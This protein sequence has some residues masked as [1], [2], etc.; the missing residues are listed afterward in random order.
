M[1]SSRDLEEPGLALVGAV[2]IVQ[3]IHGAGHIIG[4][5]VDIAGATLILNFNI[6]DLGN[7]QLFDFKVNCTT[8]SKSLACDFYGIGS[9]LGN[10]DSATDLAGAP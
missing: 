3:G 4:N 1:R 5:D 8:T 7:F 6:Q 2:N 9:A 10:A